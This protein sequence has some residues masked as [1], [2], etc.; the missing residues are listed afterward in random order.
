MQ[1]LEQLGDSMLKRLVKSWQDG[2]LLAEFAAAYE[3]MAAEPFRT[4]GRRL[5]SLVRLSEIK[6]L[7]AKR[8]LKPGGLRVLLLERCAGAY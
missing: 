4:R 8:F 1:A 6:T 3:R 5:R 2:L 7:F